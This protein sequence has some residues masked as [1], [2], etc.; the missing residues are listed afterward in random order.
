M[1][2][3]FWAAY[4]FYAHWGLWV[5]RKQMSQCSLI[6]SYWFVS[7]VIV[8]QLFYN[9]YLW[10]NDCRLPRNCQP[11]TGCKN[12]SRTIQYSVFCSFC[13]KII[14]ICHFIIHKN[15]EVL[16]KETD[17]VQFL[18]VT[19]PIICRLW[20]CVAGAALRLFSRSLYMIM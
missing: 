9:V 11:P 3:F 1:F 14:G 16:E 4:W 7:A 20:C 13:W 8:Y 17:C 19:K 6:F 15:V 5:T 2:F 12:L 10:M 18:S